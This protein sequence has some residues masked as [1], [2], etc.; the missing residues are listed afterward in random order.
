MKLKKLLKERFCQANLRLD[1]N[2]KNDFAVLDQFVADFFPDY[3]EINKL[4]KGLKMSDKNF[5]CFYNANFLP[6][7]TRD[8]EWLANYVERALS[9]LYSLSKNLKNSK[10]ESAKK[11]LPFRN[12]SK[13]YLYFTPYRCITPVDFKS[14]QKYVKLSPKFNEKRCEYEQDLTTVYLNNWMIGS[15]TDFYCNADEKARIKKA[16][17]Y[18]KLLRENVLGAMKALGVNKKSAETSLELNGNSWREVSMYK[19]FYNEKGFFNKEQLKFLARKNLPLL[20]D[21]LNK[22]LEYAETWVRLRKNEYYETHKNLINEL[23][24]TNHYKKLSSKQLAE[25]RAN[26]QQRGD[27]YEIALHKAMMIIADNEST[28]R[29]AELN[30]SI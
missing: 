7:H 19:A 10:K 30:A 26:N 24:L 16:P 1:A 2:L 23:G 13:D 21:L 28:R 11:I 8:N 27:L 29:L 17:N 6:F 18:D 14:I 3:G 12:L 20:S 9:Q 5:T 4:L 25:L 22:E 15:N